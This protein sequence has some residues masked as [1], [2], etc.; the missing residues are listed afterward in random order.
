MKNKK[1]AL[2]VA[3]P[4]IHSTL[5]YPVGFWASELFHPYEVFSQAGMEVTIASP[6]GGKVTMDA[7]S[8]PNDPSEYSAWDTLSKKYVDDSAFMAQLD[9]TV[10]VANLDLDA[11]DAFV[12]VGGQSPMFT[13][14]TATDLQ[15]A[16]SSFY[17][18][19]KVTSALCHG[20]A[21]LNYAKDAQG[22]FIAKGKKVTGFSNAEEDAVNSMMNTT[23]M[24]W[25]I[26]DELTSKGAQFV[27]GEPWKPYVVVDGNLV[28]GQQ[29]MSG[30]ITAQKVVELLQKA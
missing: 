30:E 3:N 8:N 5:N 29:N 7:E 11:Y 2:V 14:E 17:N 15:H 13:F 18:S 19:G 25:R 28:T 4:S 12:V 27:H 26:E 16:F 20:V 1:I 10:A 6:L 9:Q 22:E 23:V 24:P 21:I